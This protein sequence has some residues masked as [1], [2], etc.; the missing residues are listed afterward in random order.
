VPYI[1]CAYWVFFSPTVFYFS[2]LKHNF[3][4]KEISPNRVTLA[5]FSHT[6]NVSGFRG[7]D[8]I[9]RKQGIDDQISA[10]FSFVLGQKRQCFRRFFW[11]KYLKNQTS[12]QGL[13][14][15]SSKKKLYICNYPGSSELLFLLE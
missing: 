3:G 12:V 14:F 1:L 6:A 15:H 11:R 5:T 10:S 13:A 8:A 7:K 9:P 2:I 4:F